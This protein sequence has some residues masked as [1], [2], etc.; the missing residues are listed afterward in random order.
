ME[1]AEDRLIERQDEKKRK[2]EEAGIKYNFDAVAYVS[3]DMR[4]PGCY[5]NSLT[6]SLFIQKKKPKVEPA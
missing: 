5:C 4:V 3:A 6:A 1:K 2:L